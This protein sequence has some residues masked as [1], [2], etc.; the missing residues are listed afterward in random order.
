MEIGIGIDID[1]LAAEHIY[2]MLVHD[3][4]RIGNNDLVARIDQAHKGK[5]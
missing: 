4:I 1:T 2:Q 3:K 5:Q